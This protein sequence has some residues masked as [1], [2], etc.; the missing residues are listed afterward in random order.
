[1]SAARSIAV[2]AAGLGFTEGP[3]WTADGRL[4]VV[5]VS[6]GLIYAVGREDAEGAREGGGAEAL[7]FVVAEPGGNPTGLCQTPDGTIW[8]AQGGGHA[9]TRSER[10]TVP[11]IQAL[12]ADGR[13]DDVAV[14]GLHAPNDCVVGPDHRIWFTDPEGSALDAEGPG[15]AVRALDPTTGAVT[16]E[17]DGIRYPNGLGFTPDADALIVAETGTARLLRLPYDHGRLG[18]P[19]PLA[20]LDR[21]HPDGLAIAGDGTVLVAATDAHDVQVF[22]ADGRPRAAIAL[23]EGC[24]PTNVALSPDGATTAVTAAKGGRVLLINA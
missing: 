9:P 24:F 8:I 10:P 13:V 3:L 2:A 19:E 12:R 5:S 1:M 4:L 11:S 6:R 23:P 18:A 20:K 16:V 15:G 7:A 22:A 14:D 21:G 17:A